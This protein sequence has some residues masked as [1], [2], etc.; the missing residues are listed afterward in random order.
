[1][2]SPWKLVSVY[3]IEVTHSYCSFVV[4]AVLCEQVSGFTEYFSFSHLAQL[5]LISK[6]CPL[7]KMAFCVIQS[8]L[9]KCYI[10]SQIRKRGINQ[11]WSIFELG[12]NPNMSK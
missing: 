6:G 9:V 3:T 8:C 2:R 5:F 4:Q 7:L 11:T 1:M 10:G 12:P